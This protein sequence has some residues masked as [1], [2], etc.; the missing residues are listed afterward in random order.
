FT[1]STRSAKPAGCAMV[2][3]WAG[4]ISAGTAACGNAPP[5]SVAAP[6]PATPARNARRRAERRPR[7][8]ESSV[9]FTWSLP[10]LPVRN[11]TVR[12]G[13]WGRPHYGALSTALQFRNAAHLHASLVASQTCCSQGRQR[14]TNCPD[15]LTY[16]VMPYRPAHRRRFSS[17]LG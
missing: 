16:Q 14:I 9:E 13:T 3:A 8:A 10:W 2:W 17:G 15:I 1:F 5:I 11:G 4:A 6:R 7:A 12:P